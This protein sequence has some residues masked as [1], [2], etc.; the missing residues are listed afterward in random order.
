MGSRVC[1]CEQTR[2]VLPLAIAMLEQAVDVEIMAQCLIAISFSR[3]HTCSTHRAQLT[4]VVHR[5]L[6]KGRENLLSRCDPDDLQ[7]TVDMLQD[8][9]THLV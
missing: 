3:H 5:G 6:L 9:S 7:Q 2:H 1:A 8:T 4:M